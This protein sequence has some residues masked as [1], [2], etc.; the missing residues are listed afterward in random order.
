MSKYLTNKNW[1]GIILIVLAWLSEVLEE[2]DL[3]LWERILR[4]TFITLILVIAFQISRYYYPKIQ[5][6]ASKWYMLLFVFLILS[7]ITFLL[8]S[9]FISPTEAVES[10]KISHLTLFLFDLFVVVPILMAMFLSWTYY[11]FERN[12]ENELALS[13]LTA[14]KKESELNELKKQL[15]PHF[16]FNALSNIYSIAYLG[17]KQTPNKI[18]QLSKM[19]R[20]V[21]Y[22][23]DVEFIP[24]SKEIEYLE[25]YIDF[26]K[27][28]IKKEQQI[29]F[30]FS[31]TNGEVKIAP[32]L[33]LPF[34]ENAF[35]HSQI[36]T[37][38]DAWVKIILKTKDNR[39]HLF[40]ENTISSKAQPEILNNEGVGLENI[41]KRLELIYKSDV[42]LTILKGKT[43]KA[44]LKIGT[45]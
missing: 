14:L 25:Y 38:P 13:H 1:I 28:K 2:L 40:V 10:R 4:A 11:L 18:M 5:R 29:D 35:K 8:N 30:E 26:Q 7:V 27:F 19:L 33:L 3:T 16:L 43:F 31:D 39:V 37:E 36:A 34:V 12:K 15:N 41:K 17:D 44:D 24:L 20:Y 45:S 23:T 32:L 42:E 6:G 22:E 21:I 9:I